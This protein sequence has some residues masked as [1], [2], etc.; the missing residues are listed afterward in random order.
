M[1]ARAGM[2]ANT[3]SY[4]DIFLSIADHTSKDADIFPELDRVKW[5]EHRYGIRK[6]VYSGADSAI[7]CL[8]GS[9][10]LT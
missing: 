8:C 4:R 6:P 2:C 3:R 5:M 7:S 10:Q 1:K 9:R